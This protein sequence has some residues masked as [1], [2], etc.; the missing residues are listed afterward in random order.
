MRWTGWLALGTL[1]VVSSTYAQV[2]R[3]LPKGVR[4]LAY[5][6]V[7]TSKIDAN[8]NSDQAI[9]PISYNI[10]ANAKTLSEIGSAAEIYLQELKAINPAA[11]EALTLGEFNI[12][13]VAQVQVHGFGGGYGINDKLTVY[14][15]LPY[16]NANVQVKYRQLRQSN[17]QEV[18]DQVQQS[19]QGDIDSTIANIAENIPSASGNML[20][21]VLVNTYKY[22]EIGDWQGA[23]YADFEMGAMYRLID[24]GTWGIAV[25][26]GFVAPTGREDDPDL[27]QDIAFGDGQWDVFAEGAVG[28]V[29]NDSLMFGTT[30]RY[31]Y[32]APAEKTLRIPTDRD[33]MMSDEKGSFVV[34]YGDKIDT[35][36]SA[37]YT[38]SDWFAMTPAY[39]MN[40]QMASEYDSI[41]G[42]ANDYLAYNSDRLGHVAKLTASV[43]SVQP[44][45]KKKFMLPATINFNVQKT[46]SG[47]NVPEM[48]RYE[49]EFRMLF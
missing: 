8:Y 47:R 24:R 2:H 32:Q 22:D 30:L 35:V 21:S 28:Y 4:M 44:F 39:E 43:S 33:F 12:S 34:K 46:V 48:S 5:R 13:A 27:L 23:G 15:I 26:G 41:Y 38:I 36:F 42:K 9:A 20:Q 45:L 29:L 16:Y 10:N 17:A 3:T 40:Y 1:F 11:Y 18:A 31:T 14:G 49:V 6:N 19:G 25:T 37:T 7:N